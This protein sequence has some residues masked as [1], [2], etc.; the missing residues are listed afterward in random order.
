MTKK[1]QIHVGEFQ[2]RHFLRIK[3]SMLNDAGGWGALGY[4]GQGGIGVL[5]DID[6]ILWCLGGLYAAP[7]VVYAARRYDPQH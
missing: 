7:Q 3:N 1:T 2:E 6:Y 4:R 5:I